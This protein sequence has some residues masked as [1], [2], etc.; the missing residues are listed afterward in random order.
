MLIALGFLAASLLGLLLAPAFWSRAVRLTSRRLKERL[1][2]S[3]VEIEADRDRIRAEYAIKMHKLETLVEQVKLTGAR[4]QI[5]INRRDARINMLE[6]DIETLRAN[7]EEGQNARRVLEQTI[8]DRLPRIEGRLTE[9]KQALF[10]REREVAELTRTAER[11]TRALTEAG[12]I[13]SQRESEIERLKTSLAQRPV[14]ASRGEARAETETALRAELESIR[15][16][17]R[18]QAQLLARFQSLAGLSSAGGR[19][20]SIE[21][22][23]EADEKP[24]DPVGSGADQSLRRAEADHQLRSLQAKTED[25][26]A[27]IARL[28][29]AIAVFE[30]NLDGDGRASLRDSR[31]AMKARVQSLEAQATLQG[32][33]I[34][35]LRSELAAANERLA[36]QAAHFTGELRRLGG[37]GPR[38]S[39]AERVAQVRDSQ[40]EVI[41]GVTGELAAPIETEGARPGGDPAA[42]G[43]AMATRNGPRP[44]EITGRDA[45][46]PIKGAGGRADARKETEPASRPRLLAR[47]ANLSRTS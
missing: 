3:E 19:S 41:S 34:L 21:T 43:S 26:S 29:A 10:A 40:S 35:K 4:Q 37:G 36:R 44:V 6:T 20:A 23:R 15:A 8:A 13:N 42:D 24:A 31:I 5:E 27:E 47:L 25:Q 22:V 14:R 2:L 11:Q 39:L 17:A 12:S 33:T 16:K 18:E 45:N 1:P 38:P 46:E 28:K 7:Y 30:Q 9:A 32:D